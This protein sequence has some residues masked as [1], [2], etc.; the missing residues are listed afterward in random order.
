MAETQCQTCE[1]LR[2][3]VVSGY[4]D[5][6]IDGVNSTDSTDDEF[7]RD[8]ESS[9]TCKTLDRLFG[10]PAADSR[11]SIAARLRALADELEGI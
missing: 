8:W 1:Q 11:K 4:E 6:W 7:V 2:A 5:G 3:L 9:K 10:P